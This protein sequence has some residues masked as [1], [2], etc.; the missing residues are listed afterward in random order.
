MAPIQYRDLLKSGVQRGE[1][2]EIVLQQ[3]KMLQDF[4]RELVD[5]LG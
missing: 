5:L 2:A 3:I 1:Y 4:S